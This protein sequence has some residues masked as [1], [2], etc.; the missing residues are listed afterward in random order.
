MARFYSPYSEGKNDWM[1]MQEKKAD[2]L[3]KRQELAEHNQK[4]AERQIAKKIIK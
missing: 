3:K 1:K 2:N 4:I